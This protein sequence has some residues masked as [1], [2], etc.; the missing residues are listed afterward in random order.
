MFVTLLTRHHYGHPSRFFEVLANE[1]GSN[2]SEIL[3]RIFCLHSTFGRPYYLKERVI[4]V[5][6]VDLSSKPISVTININHISMYYFQLCTVDGGWS[7]WKCGNCF[8]HKTHG[9]CVK[10]CTRECSNPLPQHGG[11]SCI[12]KSEGYDK[13][14]SKECRKPFF[15]FFLFFVCCLFFK[16]FEVIIC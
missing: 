13:C 16:K 10:K 7:E 8:S 11:R 3:P 6:N 12:G 2:F 5:Y 9:E 15:L 14:D 1:I 4:I